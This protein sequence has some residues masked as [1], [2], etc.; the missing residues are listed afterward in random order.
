LDVVTD[1]DANTSHFEIK[2]SS[3]MLKG[4]GSRSKLSRYH[5]SPQRASNLDLNI[6]LLDRN[7]PPK[8][9]S[10]A[11]N[12]MLQMT[13]SQSEKQLD[14]GNI[15]IKEEETPYNLTIEESEQSRKSEL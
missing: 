9:K 8:V 10:R 2:K 3:T 6:P 15:E 11:N 13:Y 4:F 14:L 7:V 1:L 12:Q 5:K